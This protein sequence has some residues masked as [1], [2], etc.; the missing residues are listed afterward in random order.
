MFAI[1]TICTIYN[2]PERRLSVNPQQAVKEYYFF[3]AWARTGRE[4]NQWFLVSLKGG[5]FESVIPFL[6]PKALVCIQGDL[7]LSS[8]I[9]K[10]EKRTKL[11][12]FASS[13]N[14]VRFAPNPEL[15][16]LRKLQE[17]QAIK[18]Q[19]RQQQQVAQPT[20]PPSPA[21]VQQQQAYAQPSFVN[22]E[23][24]SPYTN[25][26]NYPQFEFDDSECPF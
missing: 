24:E 18:D 8:Y 9:Y 10:A 14:V 20:P 2:I 26:D 22:Q 25:P 12:V 7:R 11:T 1:T 23:P 15:T 13:V 3:Q 4:Q 6:K 17:Q 19:Q 16:E 21:P 5:R